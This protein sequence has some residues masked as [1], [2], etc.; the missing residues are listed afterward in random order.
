ML[1]SIAHIV[2]EEGYYIDNETFDIW[3]YK[4]LNQGIV[5]TP[6]ILQGQIKSGYIHY[7]FRVNRRK[8]SI[9]L[10]Q[11]I[12]KVFIDKDYDKCSHEIDHIDHNRLNNSIDNLRIV[13]KSDNQINKLST[14]GK[15]F[16]FV[17]NINNSITIDND[18]GIYYS[19]DTDRF[20]RKI[21]HTGKYRELNETKHNGNSTRIHYGLNGIKKE[22]C[23]S[24]FRKDLL[25]K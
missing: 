2:G 5:D 16:I 8:R 6:H 7:S 21:F 19:I 25:A 20:Y 11:I 23:T 9:P 4:H 14:H 22:F 10:H 1:L 15:K 18:F 13:S 24:K 12:V 17:D 3:S